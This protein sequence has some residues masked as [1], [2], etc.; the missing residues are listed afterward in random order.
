MIFTFDLL[1]QISFIITHGGIE[2]LQIFSNFIV[3]FEILVSY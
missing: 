1:A 3:D 2:I